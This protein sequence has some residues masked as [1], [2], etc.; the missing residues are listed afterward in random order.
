MRGRGAWQGAWHRERRR[1]A[2][3]LPPSPV[4]PLASLPPSPPKLLPSLAPPA[5]P[6]PALLRAAMAER[7]RAVE[8][9]DAAAMELARAREELAQLASTRSQTDVDATK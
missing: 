1:H 3:T 2:A 9:G 8:C 6:P 7:A 5:H 4:D